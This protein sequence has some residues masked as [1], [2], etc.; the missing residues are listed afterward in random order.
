MPRI[1]DSRGMTLVL[2]LTSFFVAIFMTQSIWLV[3]LV[4]VL[5]YWLFRGPNGNEF[6]VWGESLLHPFGG[7]KEAYHGVKLIQPQSGQGGTAA[8]IDAEHALDPSYAKRLGVDT[9]NLLVSQPNNG[10][11]A[12]EITETLI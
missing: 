5:F 2:A 11:Q 10:E 9:E 4:L 12:L 1:I 6:L 8:F 7:A 3:L